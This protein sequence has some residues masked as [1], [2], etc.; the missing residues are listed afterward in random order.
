MKGQMQM[1]LRT[2]GFARYLPVIVL[3]LGIV[4][5]GVG[6]AVRHHRRLAAQTPATAFRMITN[7][8]LF[9][10]DGKAVL[11][12]VRTKLQKG[13]GDWKEV[14]TVY[15]EDGSV[16]R[17]SQLFGITGRGVLAVHEKEHTYF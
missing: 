6:L 1:R 15:N 7:G 9:T 17:T 4:S 2:T 13:N 11:R 10:N 3:S 8:T 12:T 14:T 5:T 16:K